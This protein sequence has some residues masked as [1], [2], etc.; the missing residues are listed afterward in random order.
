MTALTVAAARCVQRG[1]R[2]LPAAV[3]AARQCAGRSYKRIGRALSPS[4]AAACSAV[5][6]LPNRNRAA[7]ALARSFATLT[8][9]PK[10]AAIAPLA[11]QLEII[12]IVQR[13][14]A[15]EELTL[16]G[17]SSYFGDFQH[18][19]F[20]DYILQK[21]AKPFIDNSSQCY[22]G[23]IWCII[24]RLKELF[25]KAPKESDTKPL[26]PF[27][28]AVIQELTKNNKIKLK[29]LNTDDFHNSLFTMTLDLLYLASRASNNE[30]LNN[31]IGNAIL[32]HVQAVFNDPEFKIRLSKNFVLANHV[33]DFLSRCEQD[34][35]EQYAR[36]GLSIPT[37][38]R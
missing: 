23:E 26:Q 15:L 12:G 31:K 22:A 33:K 13:A 34:H 24:R 16:A 29:L 32:S 8:V 1:A 20:I 7:T 17:F 6:A 38:T 19:E 9:S 35:P 10:R 21:I 14:R 4:V 5:H 28:L 30:E 11:T 27:I 25:E 37:S 18:K 3:A 2:V 36:L